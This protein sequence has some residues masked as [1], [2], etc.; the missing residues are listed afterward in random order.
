MAA[1]MDMSAVGQPFDAKR[2]SH[3]S[4]G[5]TALHEIAPMPTSQGGKLHDFDQHFGNVEDI[6]I[7]VQSSTPMQ[8]AMSCRMFLDSKVIASVSKLPCEKGDTWRVLASVF[9]DYIPVDIE[10]S[11]SAGADATTVILMK[12]TSRNDVVRFKRV[13]GSL[14]ENLRSS[15]FEVQRAS[16]EE[17]LS[18]KAG[19]V[20]D[21][22]DDFS[23]DTSSDE[24]E[25]SWLERVKLALTDF[26][27]RNSA[28]RELAVQSLARWA[29]SAPECHLALAQGLADRSEWVTKVFFAK[30]PAPL[31][32][33]Y[34]MVATL[35]SL[36]CSESA[37]VNAVLR[38]SALAK[39]MLKY[40]P[41]V[42]GLPPLVASELM[43]VVQ[44]IQEAPLKGYST[45]PV[46]DFSTAS[47][48]CTALGSAHSFDGDSSVASDH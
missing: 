5:K 26:D 23:D 17:P 22:F 12:H 34:P 25:T 6:S 15:G 33:M 2:S 11:T 27:A 29:A 45:Q 32:E 9:S 7:V 38:K 31:T 43:I 40:M 10:L 44:N 28:I 1:V 20:D 21:D 42:G 30:R 35:R 3:A 39:L 46:A 4:F 16:S 19:L 41:L 48:C 8:V 18:K 13:S 24:E 47:T 37:E 36:V 14:V